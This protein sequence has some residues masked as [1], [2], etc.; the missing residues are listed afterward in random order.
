MQRRSTDWQIPDPALT[1]RG[2]EQCAALG[3]SLKSQYTFSNAET[4]I[5][6]SPFRRTL[7]SF[8]HT[9]GWLAKEGVPVQLRAEWQETTDNPCDVGIDVALAQSEW[10]DL[11]FSKLDPVYPAKT[12]LYGPSEEALCKRALF[13]R[14]WLYSRREKYIIVVTHSGFLR[15]VVD[16]PKFGNMEYRI[17]DFAPEEEGATREFKLEEVLE[18]EPLGQDIRRPSVVANLV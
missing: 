2:L 10:P 5:V 4:L 15:R 8:Q 17:Y 3:S 1:E 18:D 9:L 6:V 14:R 13:A 7:Q 16:G 12:G 11:D